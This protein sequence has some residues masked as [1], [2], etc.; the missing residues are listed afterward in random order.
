M[1]SGHIWPT[2][3]ESSSEG[4]LNGKVSVTKNLDSKPTP[5]KIET[6][7]CICSD[8]FSANWANEYAEMRC[9]IVGPSPM[10]LMSKKK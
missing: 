1:K 4:C 3:D 8:G 10:W 5:V 6:S 9:E 2:Q 7:Q